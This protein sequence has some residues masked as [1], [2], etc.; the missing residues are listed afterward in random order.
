[1]PLSDIKDAGI[2]ASFERW[3]WPWHGLI[4]S[5]TIASTGQ[6]HTQPT[7]CDS[8]LIDKGLDPIDL[9]PEQIAAYAADGMEWRNY[10]LIPGGYVYNTDIGSDA[11]I[12]VDEAGDCWRVELAFS[13]PATNTL[14]ITATIG[15]FGL[16]VPSDEAPDPPVTVE[17]VVDVACEEIELNNAVA[18]AT[19]GIPYTSRDARLFDVWTNGSKAIAGVLLNYSSYADLFS[20]AEIT[21]TGEGG[22][23][24]STLSVSAVEIKGQSS[25][26][27]GAETW[28]DYPPND[29]YSSTVNWDLIDSTYADVCPPEPYEGRQFDLTYQLSDPNAALRVNYDKD[30]E[31]DGWTVAR[32]AFYDSA[33][34][35]RAAR[36]R[37]GDIV[38]ME[39]TWLTSDWTVTEVIHTCT[40]TSTVNFCGAPSTIEW[41]SERPYNR[42]YT[43]KNT[44]Q[45]LLD[46]EPQDEIGWSWINDVFFPIRSIAGEASCTYGGTTTDNTYENLGSFAAYLPTA[47]DTTWFEWATGKTPA[48]MADVFRSSADYAFSDNA[49]QINSTS[50][51]FGIHRINHNALAFVLDDG[52]N[53]LY[54]DV[55][56]PLGILT[57]P[58][59]PAD[60]THF[61]WQRK[62]DDYTFATS[63]ICYV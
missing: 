62:T 38:H 63:A 46:D 45:I 25:L 12:H 2:L 54:G 7:I 41:C 22:D 13:F 37:Y 32:Y 8:W 3:G 31:F 20:V 27:L 24:G 18:I 14:R 48:Y 43:T 35:A 21:I 28:T 19:F 47:S 6:D 11:Y 16:I 61:A 58:L 36:L 60:T 23:D 15:R 4:Q 30:V 34:N 50:I 9:T 51:Y 57:A 59:A 39:L 29:T 55:I 1:M 26:T 10:A 56:T 33:G 52:T 42:I 49:S 40:C 5:D 17:K 53:Y 44:I